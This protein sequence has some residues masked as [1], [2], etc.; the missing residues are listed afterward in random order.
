MKFK[1]NLQLPV[2]Y[3]MT[4]PGAQ[5]KLVISDKYLNNQNVIVESNNIISMGLMAKKLTTNF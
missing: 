5:C 3:P 1:L 4:K 2:D